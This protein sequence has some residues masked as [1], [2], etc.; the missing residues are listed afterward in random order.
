MIHDFLSGAAILARAIQVIK[1]PDV[2]LYAIVPLL[3]NIVLFGGLIW[4]GYAQLSHSVDWLMSFVPGFLDLLR[5]IIWAFITGLTTIVVFFTF[6]P[7][8]NIVAA[9]FNALLAER[10]EAVLTGKPLESTASFTEIA[11]SSI[12]SQ[13]GKLIYILLWSLGLLLIS[14]IPVINFISPFLWI[15]FGSWL[16]SLEYFDYPMGNHDLS[17]AN[18]KKRLGERR[19]LILGFGGSVMV[20][21]TIPLINFV[22]MPLAVAGATIIWVE[23]LADSANKSSSSSNSSKQLKSQPLV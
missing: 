7:I 15:I 8:A 4:F 9:P 6:T 14:F 13:F 3:I 10:I 23:Q 5:W 12:R 2:R 21:T 11:I 16:L 17:F 20:L 19:G 18:Q 22:V 1:R